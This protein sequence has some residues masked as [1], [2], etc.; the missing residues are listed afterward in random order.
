[1]HLREHDAL[2]FEKT[3]QHVLLGRS[4]AALRELVPSLDKSMGERLARQFAS[5]MDL[6][7]LDASVGKECLKLRLKRLSKWLLENAELRRKYVSCST[8][9]AGSISVVVGH[10]PEPSNGIAESPGP[11]HVLKNFVGLQKFYE[12]LA[13]FQEIR[14]IRRCSALWTKF[15]PQHP[16]ISLS[17]HFDKVLDVEADNDDLMPAPKSLQASISEEDEEDDCLPASKSL[18]APIS[19]IYFHTR[20]VEAM[21][22][23][24][25][26]SCV[27]CIP[28]KGAPS[29][30][31]SQRCG[32][33]VHRTNW[34]ELLRDSKIKLAA[35][36]KFE[37]ES[38]EEGEN[39]SFTCRSGVCVFGPRSKWC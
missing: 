23:S 28:P 2:T 15:S 32:C 26:V 13:V 20:L 30:D 4:E 18:P 17:K 36:R 37:K 21:G 8:Y 10:G 7:S 25:A 1:M 5:L 29:E 11:Y 35:F 34:D 12:I 39:L 22:V 16:P 38:I 9:A 19:D 33:I 31:H 14:C 27:S 24:D 6:Q 3:I